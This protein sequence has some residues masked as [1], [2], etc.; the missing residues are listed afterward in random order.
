MKCQISG[1]SQNFRVDLFDVDSAN[2]EYSLDR[3][4]P[5]FNW[6][7]GTMLNGG[8]CGIY[9][10]DTGADDALGTFII[11]FDDLGGSGHTY[12]IPGDDNTKITFFDCNSNNC[13]FGTSLKGN[14]VFTLALFAFIKLFL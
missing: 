7:N 8:T 9:E 12:T 13:S 5:D 3:L 10:D 1:T 2:R 11:H 6:N 4:I 14:V